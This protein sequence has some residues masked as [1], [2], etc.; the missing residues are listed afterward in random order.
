MD[1]YR[2]YLAGEKLYHFIWHRFADIIIEESKKI[3]ENGTEIEK[4]SRKQFLLSSL[5]EML[6]ALHPFMPYVT[7]EIWGNMQVKDKNL[8][9]VEEWPV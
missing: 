9:I 1:N 8:L 5:A 4:L 7:E 3:L 2:Y 6:K